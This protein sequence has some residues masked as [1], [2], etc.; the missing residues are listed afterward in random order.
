MN[1][2]HISTSAVQKPVT[3]DQV[4]NAKAILNTAAKQ[5]RQEA[6]SALQEAERAVTAIRRQQQKEDRQLTAEIDKLK[7]QRDRLNEKYAAQLSKAVQARDK[8]AAKAGIIVQPRATKEEP[9][10]GKVSKKVEKPEEEE[11]QQPVKKKP[12]KQ[13]LPTAEDTGTQK[14]VI[15]K[16]SK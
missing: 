5:Q 7:S 15:K 1:K 3:P 8:A 9:K 6:R 14:K 12:V 11:E 16:P 4:K 10:K 2:I 13:N